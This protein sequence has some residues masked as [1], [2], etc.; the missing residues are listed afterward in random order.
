MH[1]PN[2]SSDSLRRSFNRYLRRIRASS[3]SDSRISCKMSNHVFRN[4][5]SATYQRNYEM[6]IEKCD[7]V[8]ISA[9]ARRCSIFSVRE[10]PHVSTAW[11][12]YLKSKLMHVAN[13]RKRTIS[14]VSLRRIHDFSLDLFYILVFIT[15]FTVV[16]FRNRS[17]YV[18]LNTQDIL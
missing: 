11:I 14:E 5:Y 13:E 12:R 18:P 6:C 17:H 9:K 1:V 10:Q 3:S 4:D 2:E 16:I 7:L 15:P 8:L